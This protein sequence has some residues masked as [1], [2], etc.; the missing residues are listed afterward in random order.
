MN[1]EPGSPVFSPDGTA[2]I[3]RLIRAGALDVELAALLWLL[4]DARTPV[5]VVGPRGSGGD[6]FADALMGLVTPGSRVIRVE[7]DDDFAWMPE[8]AELGW[9]RERPAAEVRRDPPRIAPGNAVL[10]VPG[11]AMPSGVTG[12]RARIVVRAVAVGYAML[13]TMSG[14]GLEDAL[15]ALNEPAIGTT[16]D[17]RSSLG[18]VLAVEAGGPGPRVAAAHYVRPVAR[19][20]S[21]HVQRLPPGLLAAWN[22]R[23][24]RWDHFAWGLLADLG[25]RTGL[26]PIE[27]EQA[28]AG[29]AAALRVAAGAP[30]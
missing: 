15:E 5:L 11:L 25:G 3:V 10:V 30:G 27:L 1:E 17:E 4:V 2:G 9:R 13:A 24:A 16:A 7:P 21:G 6:E 8:A 26:G 12:S 29:R 28:Q 18:V 23:S 19:D 22:P 20:S 14:G